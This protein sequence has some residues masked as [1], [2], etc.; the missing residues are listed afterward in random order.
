MVRGKNRNPGEMG[1]GHAQKGSALCKVWCL[2]LG[3]QPWGL[4][5]LSMANHPEKALVLIGM[6]SFT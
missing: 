4:L 5:G 1:S 2:G 6:F 3:T